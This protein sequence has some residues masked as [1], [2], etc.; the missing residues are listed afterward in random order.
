MLARLVGRRG[1]RSGRRHVRGRHEAEG[2]QRG[3]RYLGQALAAVEG[4]REIGGG[5][6]RAEHEP[7]R[8]ALEV[9]HH[10]GGVVGG[11]GNMPRR[12][13]AHVAHMARKLD[14]V[15]ERMHADCGEGP[16]GRLL[17]CRTPIVR[18]DELPGAGRVLRHHRDDLAETPVFQAVSDLDYRWMEAPAETDREQDAGFARGIDRST[19]ALAIERDRL[20]DVDV[21]A[22]RRR[23]Q[24]LLLV[25]AMRRRE[26][27][28]VDV[29]IGEDVVIAA[30]E[31]DGFLAAEILCARSRAG[32][33]GDETDVIALALHRGDQ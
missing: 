29:W 6:D 26:H 30:R 12:D 20:L 22:C 11:P 1:H 13:A 2:L 8:P 15:V 10:R 31:R 21:L 4:E 23:R 28:G 17:G 18:G 27:H 7:G 3:L 33:R 19:R 32:M 14:H 16:A 25:L 9:Q 24:H 5:C